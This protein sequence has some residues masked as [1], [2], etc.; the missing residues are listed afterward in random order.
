LSTI[1]IDECGYTGQNLLDTVQPIFTLASLNL[2]ES[3]CINLKNKFFGRVKSVELKYSSLSRRPN[4]QEMIINFIKT[5]AESPEIVK[6]AVAHKQFVLISKMVEM[7]V[8]PACHADGIDLYD[9]GTNLSFANL[10]FYTL[11]VFAGENLFSDLLSTFQDM[12]RSRTIPSYQ[13]F[14]GLVLAER[15]SN[16]L[17]EFLNFFRISHIRFGYKLLQTSDHLDI[18]VSLTLVLMSLWQKDAND[19]LVLIHDRSSAMAKEKKIWESIVDPQLAPIEIGYDRR[20]MQFPIRV[21]KT[22]SE[23]SKKWAG[24]QLADILAGAFTTSARWLLDGRNNDDHFG[25]KLT[26]LIGEF[27]CF[28]IVPEPKFTPEQLETT[29]ENAFPPIDYFVNLFMQNESILGNET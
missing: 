29:E 20:K 21:V 28:P 1:F 26:E 6:F 12:M 11:P 25:K 9:K 13:A 22:S 15:G 14:F 27:D 24:L 2:S 7:L 18:A 23:D 5:I 3:D 17:N 8:E 10:L 16:N 19:N 4:Q